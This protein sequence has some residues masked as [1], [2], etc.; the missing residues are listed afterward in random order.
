MD[1]P[2]NTVGKSNMIATEETRPHNTPRHLR[3][4][5]ERYN[6]N[7]HSTPSKVKSRSFV[8]EGL[9]NQRLLHGRACLE[10]QGQCSCVTAHIRPN[11]LARL[12]T[13]NARSAAANASYA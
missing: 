8:R 9:K 13:Q 3:A 1:G 5:H 4:R 10:A 11:E 6:K 2:Y 12:I 7:I